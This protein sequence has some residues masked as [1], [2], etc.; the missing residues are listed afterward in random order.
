MTTE[1][2]WNLNDFEGPKGKGILQKG[3]T[4]K[5]KN[6]PVKISIQ[7]YVSPE[8]KTRLEQRAQKVGMS[9]SGYTGLLLTRMNFYAD[10]D[11]KIKIRN[12]ADK[13]GLSTE[14]YLSLIHI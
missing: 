6:M 11:E 7:S 12:Q 4:K 14:S 2:E 3:Q 5:T 8:D 13:E 1:K 10:D 9:L